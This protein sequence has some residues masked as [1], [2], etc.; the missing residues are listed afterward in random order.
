MPVGLAGRPEGTGG[1][2][3]SGVFLDPVA[4]LLVLGGSAVVAALR[5]TAGDCRAAIAALTPMLRARPDID[6]QAARIAVNRIAE[7]AGAT[8][9][10][11]VDRAPVVERFLARAAAELAD[12]ADADAFAGWANDDVDMRA[13]RHARVHGVWR[14]AADAAPAMGMIGTVIGLIRMFAA[15]DDPMQIGPGMALALTTT[16]YGII[17]ANLIAGPIAA[18]LERLSEAEIGW[19]RRATERLA[20]IARA[21]LEGPPVG[22]TGPQLK[23]VA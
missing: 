19:Q 9:L 12:A 18:R 21:E 23:V 8:G 4:P 6:G 11:T 20:G 13:L 15:M 22:R 14:A 10:A 3:Y 1:G 16:L 17:A 5:S 2:V 7:R